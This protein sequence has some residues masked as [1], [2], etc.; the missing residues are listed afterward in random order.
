VT[1]PRPIASVNVTPLIDVLLVL[2]IVFM[3]IVPERTRAL[4]VRVPEAQERG[5]GATADP[6]VLG[7]TENAMTLNGRPVASLDA[8]ALELAP[9]FAGQTER[10]LFVRTSEGV[11]YGSLVEALDVARGAGA[12]RIGLL[13]RPGLRP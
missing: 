3:V 9:L 4:D 5:S 8:L 2:L 12:R 13:P 1:P 10:A 7:L 11:A 6:V